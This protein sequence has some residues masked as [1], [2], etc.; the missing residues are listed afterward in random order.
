MVRSEQ[1]GVDGR[2]VRRKSSSPPAA[3]SPIQSSQSAHLAACAPHGPNLAAGHQ[4]EEAD[5]RSLSSFTVTPALTPTTTL[6]PFLDSAMATHS[7][8]PGAPAAEG[9]SLPS[10]NTRGETSLATFQ[11]LPTHLK[12]TIIS[13][14]CSAPGGDRKEGDR[15]LPSLNPQP[16]KAMALVSKS[17]Y[18]V[19]CSVLYA[20][21]R[22]TRISSL[23]LLLDAV[24]SRPPLGRLM[25]TLHVGAD[26]ES[27]SHWTPIFDDELT[28]RLWLPEDHGKW[29]TWVK[30]QH[31]FEIPLGRATSSVPPAALGA[32]E[33]AIK[34]ACCA[35]DV[36]LDQPGSSGRSA[37]SNVSLSNA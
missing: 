9:N 36:E 12:T 6:G 4:V 8:G 17:F 5:S 11:L 33:A 32:I 34:S 16:A 15:F 27:V 10:N 23:K 1:D 35:L 31:M 7:C 22:V 24:I 18:A 21:I 14:A 2:M 37:L 3:A 13:M 26:V 19:G 28:L 25:K 29:P 20:H 30:G